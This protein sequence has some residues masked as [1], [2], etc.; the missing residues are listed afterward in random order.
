VTLKTDTLDWKEIEN[1]K[2]EN[3]KKKKW[4]PVKK[5]IAR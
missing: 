4:F 5:K 2:V 3:C 1:C